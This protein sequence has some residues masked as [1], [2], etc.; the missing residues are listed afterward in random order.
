[1]G[2]APPSAPVA[3]F[4]ALA[5]AFLLF[6]LGYLLAR[7]I[8]RWIGSGTVVALALAVPALCAFVFGLMLIHIATRGAILSTPWLPPVAVLA[9]LLVLGRRAIA[10]RVE[11]PQ[12]AARAEIF[13]A[14]ALVVVAL[15]VWGSP[16]FRLLPLDTT[17]GD[18]PWH[19]GLSSQ[20]L[21]GESTPSAA[22]T[23]SVPSYYPWLYHSVIA[24]VARFTPGAK[25][26]LALGPLQM[27]LAA[28]SA[29]AFFAI[30]REIRG[31]WMTGAFAAL[32]G[33]IA[34]GVGFVRL[35]GLDVVLTPRGRGGGR[36]WG[37][38]LY[39]RSYNVAFAN[40][41]P[42]YP[43]DLALLLLATF[44]LLAGI[45][46]ARDQPLAL[47][48]A[49]V[50]LGLSGLAGG[51][52][53]L[54]GL[55]VVAGV[56]VLPHRL[57]RFRRALALILP[58][59][60]VYCVWL[61]PVAVSYLRL[62]GFV[63][64]TKVGAV[65]L[66]LVAILGAWGVG[67]LFAVVGLIWWLPKVRDTPWARV[68]AV[69]LAASAVALLL[70][71]L[72]TSG[73]GRGFLSLSRR[74]RYWPLLH[75]AVVLYAA[76][77]AGEVMDRLLRPDP[78][79]ASRPR[80]WR[81]AAPV[82]VAVAAATLALPSPVVASL[83]LPSK[84]PSDPLLEAAFR[85]RTDSVLA[86]LDRGERACVAAVPLRMDA[87][88]FAYTGYRLVAF[89]WHGYRRNL[90]RIRWRRLYAVIPGDA[91]R[92]EA[93]ASLVMASDPASF[94]R[95]AQAFGANVVVV[96]GESEEALD[97]FPRSEATGGRF[98]YLVVDVRSC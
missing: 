82:A 63:N 16:V 85:G 75:L 35:R 49:G 33:A 73:L 4:E 6:G 37:D 7:P 62:G 27:L 93:N 23:G 83:A 13:A 17:T 40:L 3:G 9:T 50:A 36:Y 96:E 69:V 28:G 42:P 20:L 26:Y 79:A 89:K 48:G 21:N 12:R 44:V 1:M 59:F 29:L 97:A 94:Q 38:L 71:S 66:G 90:A 32:F 60:A 95:A 46:Y 41:S 54:L 45:G 31:S 70:S 5:I 65:R 86:R 77:G 61:V 76:V 30:G 74:H 92:L 55:L 19:M 98:H 53:L 47:S 91:A 10:H 43:R 8:A 81:L 18:L 15:L 72:V 11:P 80:R 51:E 22:V 57:G 24:F 25:A 64:I 67:V 84:M 14:L 56:I 68:L 52:T 34:G 78:T 58:T 39:K 2:S 88:A 87:E